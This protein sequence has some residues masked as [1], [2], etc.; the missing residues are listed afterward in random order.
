MSATQLPPDSEILTV[1]TLTRR[2][3][4]LLEGELAEVWIRGEI[5]NYRLQSSGHAY[6]SL[7]DEKSQVLGVV[8]RGD[9][10]RLRLALA[11]GIA[12]I[13]F[14]RIS[15]YEPRGSYQLIVRYAVEDGRGRLQLEF[16]RLKEKL[17]AEGLFDPDRKLP[18]PTLPL[19]VG[20]VTSPTGAAIR[21]FISIL[22]RRGWR[23]R[24]VVLPTK[25]QGSGAAEEIVQR[26]QF[27]ENWGVF[28]LIVVG[29]GGGSL[30]DLWPF[31]EEIV[32]RAVAHCSIPVLSAVGHEIDFTLSDLAASKRAE[33]PSAAA[34]MISSRYLEIM[35][36][37]ETAA[38]DIEMILGE[39]IERFISRLEF[40]S[41]RIL[42]LSPIRQV[43]QFFIRL[44]D[45][46]NR[47]R[48]GL[49]SGIEGRNVRL[50]HCR[51]RLAALAP[52]AR[53][54][55]ASTKLDSLGRRSRR[56]MNDSIDRKGLKLRFLNR[57]LE[58]V[59]PNCILERGFVLVSDE[60]GNLIARK[61]GIE[62]GQ[63]LISRFADGELPVKVI[64]K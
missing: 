25:V 36:R 8:F 11:D 42:G 29:R 59:S 41:S 32:A 10:A 53:V 1:S 23:G 34:E 30:E 6:F 57:R 35:E 56:A 5:S 48:S 14:G 31:N 18:L 64:E 55:L 45:L 43:E 54:R 15:V 13:A 19:T 4:S 44:D 49:L 12:V 39:A 7:K 2:I 60:N 61:E 27:A 50:Q 47:I 63:T 17:A 28:D 21:D 40:L 51:T 24:V 3:K 16:E 20:F 26:L 58:S 33:T 37:L 62:P 38:S 22:E 46:E 9:A 52:D